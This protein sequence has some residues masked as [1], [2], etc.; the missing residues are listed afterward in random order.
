MI[1]HD[2]LLTLTEVPAEEREIFEEMIKDYRKKHIKP[3][4]EVI[5]IVFQKNPGLLHQL[6]KR[7]NATAVISAARGS[8]WEEFLLEEAEFNALLIKDIGKKLK[9][10]KAIMEKIISLNLCQ[11][12]NDKL[13]ES[14]QN[15]C[16]EYAG[17]VSSYIYMLSLSNTN[18]RRSRA[19]STFQCILYKMYE[20]LGYSYDS[21]KKVGKNAFQEKGLGKIVDSILPGIGEFEKRR[22]KTIIG[23]MKTTL[24]ER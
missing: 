14:I 23:T 2:K 10:P 6:E 5:D 16:G 3:A 8:A 20:V 1:T 15:I 9:T 22:D 18:S 7:G 4:G 11:D 21:Q 17:R 12:T 24:R 19:G 13:I